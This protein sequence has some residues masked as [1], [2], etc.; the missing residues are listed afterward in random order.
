[1]KLSQGSNVKNKLSRITYKVKSI[2][3]NSVVVEEDDGSDQEWTMNNLDIF[4]EEL[5][6]S[7]KQGS[8]KLC[9][10][11]RPKYLGKWLKL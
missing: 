8:G 4:F 9:K 11:Q 2:T 5:S 1:M 3:H 7:A 10:R 6:R